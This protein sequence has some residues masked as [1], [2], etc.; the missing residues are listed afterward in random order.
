[1]RLDPLP[2]RVLID[3]AVA[4]ARA[5][6]RPA[7][8]PVALPFAALT[9]A[10]VVSQARW[11]GALFDFEADAAADTMFADIAFTMLMAFGVIAFQVIAY[12]AVTVVA[13]DQIAGRPLS[14]ARAWRFAFR[15]GVLGTLIVV[16][17]I[18][19]LSVLFC[20]VPAI[21]FIPLLSL[22]LPIMVEEDI[23]GATAISRSFELGNFNPRGRLMELPWIQ[24]GV[25]LTVGFLVAQ[26]LTLIIQ[27]PLMVY[28]QV[29]IFRAGSQ[30]ETDATLAV[31]NATVWAQV[32]S[33]FLGA[34]AQTASW[35][36]SAAAIGLLYLE[37]RR[38]REGAD[39][40]QAVRAVTQEPA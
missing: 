30:G 37:V 31:M 5:I 2:Y 27:L 8:L 22:A 18:M 7:L 13:M 10:L 33:A 29:L 24:S 34:F 35:L 3:R 1:M 4:P 19:V 9:V 32:P 21:Y 38:R 14:F 39:L 16:T 15:P 36:Y 26:G 6:F 28:Q 20:L 23:F 25:V 17:V 11:M 40:E 12:T